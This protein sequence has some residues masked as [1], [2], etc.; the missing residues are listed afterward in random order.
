MP[1]WLHNEI[2]GVS[3]ELIASKK[4][5]YNRTSSSLNCGLLMHI[6]ARNMEVSVSYPCLGEQVKP[7]VPFKM[8]SMAI[9]IG[10]SAP[11]NIPSNN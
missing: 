2:I 9:V 10:Q 4:G 8:T 3:I 6:T 7:T 5:W 1:I 11:S